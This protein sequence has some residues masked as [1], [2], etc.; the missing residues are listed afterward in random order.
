CV[1]ET[2]REALRRIGF[3]PASY[4]E[5]DWQSLVGIEPQFKAAARAAVAE[6]H[7]I[8]KQKDWVG[9]ISSRAFQHE[10]EATQRAAESIDQKQASSTPYFAMVSYL[11]PHPPYAAPP[12]F[13]ELYAGRKFFD[14]SSQSLSGIDWDA[15]CAQY[16][17]AVSWIDNCIGVLLDVVDDNTVIIFM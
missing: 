4:T 17:G 15:L 9:K 12:P 7:Q 2:E 10:E 8:M 13:S 1:D 5:T 3:G 16:Y 11:G 14:T 6:H